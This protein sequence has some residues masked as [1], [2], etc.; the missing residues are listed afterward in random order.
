MEKLH[1]AVDRLAAFPPIQHWRVDRYEQR[2]ARAQQ[3]NLFRGVFA[4]YAEAER[5]APSTKPIGY[6]H[7]EPA[8]MYEERTRLVYPSDYPV[9][10]WLQRLLA[11]GACDSLF[12]LGGHIGVGYY[13]YQ[14][15]LSYPESLSWRVCDVPAVVERGREWAK[16][17]D[18]RGQISFTDQLGEATGKDLF[19]ASGSLQYL[20]HTLAEI[21]AGLSSRPRHLLINLLPL[22][23]RESYFTLQNIGTAFCP[24][25]IG[26]ESG[27]IRDITRLGYQL[28]DRWQ[29]LEKACFIPFHAEH[30]LDRYH[31]FYFKVAS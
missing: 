16:T 29:N 24:Y 7:P 15:Y 22:H 8:A 9:L 19:F 10:F 5:S 4:G 3:V 17:H 14:R 28:V 31:G 2:F 1:L 25:R 26:A 11:T 20:P 27:F 21:L 18:R 30:S 23:P 12:D 13:A 6:D